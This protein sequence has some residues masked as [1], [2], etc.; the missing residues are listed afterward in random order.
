MGRGKFKDKPNGQRNFSTPEELLVGTLSHLEEVESDK[1]EVEEIENPNL[2]KSKNVKAKNADMEKKIELSSRER[3][4][5]E[6]QKH[7]EQ[8]MK[9]QEQGKAKQARK[10]L[11]CLA[12]I[13]QQRVEAAKK[14]QEEQKKL[15]A[16]K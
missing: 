8:Y 1:E 3:K 6:K 4:E 12:L 9:L 5:I 7:H 15:M 16:P 11:E 13:R 10:D 14:C 2:S